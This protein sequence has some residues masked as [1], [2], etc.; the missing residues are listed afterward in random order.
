MFQA[1]RYFERNESI[2]EE[3]EN[4]DC[5]FC[6]GKHCSEFMNKL[7]KVF[8]LNQYN[9]LCYQMEFIYFP[10]ASSFPEHV[11]TFSEPNK[12]TAA[13]CKNRDIRPS[14]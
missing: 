9:K 2:S 8:K 7:Q 11:R 10:D 6:Y 13:A 12:K 14:C 5:A 4:N 1:D 3:S